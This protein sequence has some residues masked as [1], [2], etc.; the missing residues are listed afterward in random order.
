MVRLMTKRVQAQFRPG[1]YPERANGNRITLQAGLCG[2]TAVF[3]SD[4][5]TSGVTCNQPF[6]CIF[7]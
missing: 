5:W 3:W 4:R 2:G 7:V 6:H 1:L